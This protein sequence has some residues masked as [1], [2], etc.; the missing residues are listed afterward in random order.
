MLRPANPRGPLWASA[1]R[2]VGTAS[3][4]KAVVVI[5]KSVDQALLGRVGV[6]KIELVA[7]AKDDRPVRHLPGAQF[8][9]LRGR[10]GLCGA[11]DNVEG[12]RVDEDAFIGVETSKLALVLRSS[13]KLGNSGNETER[14]A[15]SPA[16]TLSRMKPSWA[17]RCRDAP[18]PEDLSQD[19]PLRRIMQGCARR[20]TRGKPAIRQLRNRT[21]AGSGLMRR[22]KR[23][24]VGVAGDQPPVPDEVGCARY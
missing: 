11:F 6:D 19:S 15:L 5:P 1:G 23:H 7:G 16:S 21:T 3:I 24:A 8:H 9:D 17:S 4:V 12:L 2:R 20:V 14:S 22:S 18:L 10:V 13:C